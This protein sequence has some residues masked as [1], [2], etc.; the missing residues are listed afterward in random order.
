MTDIVSELCYQRRAGEGHKEPDICSF[1]TEELQKNQ[2]RM[3]KLTP[4]S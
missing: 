4:A 1:L 2:Q 3:R